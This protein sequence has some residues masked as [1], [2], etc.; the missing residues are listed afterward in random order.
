MN[1]GSFAVTLLS[2]VVALGV[3]VFVHELGHFLVAKKIGVFVQRFSIGFGPV[4]FARRRGETEYAVSAVPLGGYVKMLGEDDEEEAQVDPARAFSTQ[5]VG[6][7]AAIVFAG[8]A[9]NLVF[10]FVAYA[11]LFATV[12]VDMPSNQPLVGGV[13]AGLP[14]ERAGLRAGD[15]IVEIDGAPIETWEELSKR[16]VASKGARLRLTVERDGT[17]FPL[18]ITPELQPN[19]TINGETGESYRIGIE[20]SHDW[21][22]V[23][24]L[25]AVLMAGEQTWG[26]SIVI[27]KGLGLIVTGRVS[28]SELG[29]PIAI[30]R[31]AGQQARAGVRY[32]LAT[33]ALLSV[34][35]AVLNLLPVP[36]LDGGHLAFFAV[37]GVMRRPLQRRHRELA[38]Q[39]GLLLLVT[40]IVFVSYNDIHRLLKDWLS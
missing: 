20:I 36:M 29:G 11:A 13:S 37:E 26:M 4:I 28:A 9:M 39:V 7:R 34:N 18:E 5:S 38:M 10:A 14:A 17:R 15:R 24:P 27:L 8:P 31:A 6:R 1:I 30:A 35:L 12:G 2:F 32:F 25:K 16:I 3:L 22:H 19:R 23:G 40:L 33:L 21:E